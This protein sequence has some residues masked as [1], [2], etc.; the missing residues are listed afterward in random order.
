M[1]TRL[2]CVS[3][4]GSEHACEELPSSFERETTQPKEDLVVFGHQAGEWRR[5]GH[6][7]ARTLSSS[8]KHILFFSALVNN[9][10][11]NMETG[12]VCLPRS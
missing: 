5:L 9:Y 12:A 2:S 7:E 6:T 11:D 1:A 4:L 8:C 10:T 3:A